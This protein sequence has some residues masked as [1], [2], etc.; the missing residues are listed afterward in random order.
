[1]SDTVAITLIM[2]KIVQPLLTIVAAAAGSPFPQPP[3]PFSGHGGDLQHQPLDEQ[4]RLC[5]LVVKAH[6]SPQVGT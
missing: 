1:M 2:D 3:P 6:V 5:V 4:Y